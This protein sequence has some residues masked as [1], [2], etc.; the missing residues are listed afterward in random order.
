MI[1][2]L[3][4]DET[5]S[6]LAGDPLLLQLR[7]DPCDGLEVRVYVEHDELQP[8]GGSHHEVVG[9]GEPLV[10]AVLREFAANGGDNT[11][12]ILNDGYPRISIAQLGFDGS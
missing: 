8:N 10:L 5:R 6:H 2:S 11:P 9:D 3:T 7:H 12:D 1:S 4:S